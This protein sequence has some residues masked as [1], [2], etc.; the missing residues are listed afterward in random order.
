MSG[1]KPTVTIILDKER[2]LLLSIN[3]M[4]SFEEAT[5]K[6]IMQGLEMDRFSAKD[7]RALLWACLKHEDP[8][9]T[10]EAIGDLIHAGNMT[11]IITAITEAWSKAM[12]ETK[13]DPLTKS[14]QSP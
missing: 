11:E 1:I 12:P 7:L 3:A 8:G 5:G 10:Q 2:H 13:T 6:N 14:P 9:L 4:V